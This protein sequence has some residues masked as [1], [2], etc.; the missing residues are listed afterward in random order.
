M[1]LF[2]RPGWIDDLDDLVVR[3]VGLRSRFPETGQQSWDWTQL[4]KRQ[5]DRQP[6]ELFN[7]LLSLIDAGALQ[8]FGPSE[9]QELLEGA[10]R[11]SGAPGWDLVTSMLEAGSWRI[12][13]NVR[14]WIT[15]QFPVE[16]VTG[17]IGA[18]A[19]RAQIVA[20]VANAGVTIRIRLH[21]TCLSTLAMKLM[22]PHPWLA[23][24]SA[25]RGLE[26][27]QTAFPVRLPNCGAGS[28][29]RRSQTE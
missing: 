24:S 23:T 1:A 13:M 21:A 2:Q 7:S 27:C 4:A 28:S 19:G 22:W 12:Q 11:A 5:L 20:A 14:G 15:D 29:P 3:L 25:V 18:D 9:D 8:I 16:L 26:T 6:F 17:W 10:F